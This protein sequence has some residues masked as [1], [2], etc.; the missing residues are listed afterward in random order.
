M[1]CV[2]CSDTIKQALIKSY[3]NLTFEFDYDARVLK[4]T[5]DVDISKNLVIEEIEK[6]GYTV[7]SIKS[8]KIYVQVD[9]IVCSFCLIG[10]KK[11]FE[12]IDHIKEANF[13]LDSGF[14]ELVLAPNQSVSDNVINQIFLDSGYEVKLIKR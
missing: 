14:L 8:N 6:L 4:L 9:G 11:N 3:E 1:D 2:K 12:Q 5:S 13:N 7:N 10:I